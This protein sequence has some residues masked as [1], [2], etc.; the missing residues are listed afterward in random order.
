LQLEPKPIPDLPKL[1]HQRCH[2]TWNA[3]Q[4]I[5]RPSA[6]RVSGMLTSDAQG[7]PHVVWPGANPDSA[8]FLLARALFFVPLL[9]RGATARLVTKAHTWEQAASRAFA[10]ELLAP[11]DALRA[12]VG[13]GVSQEELKAVASHFQVSSMVIEHQLKNNRIGWIEEA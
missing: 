7:G 11:A 10:A 5:E 3:D 13:G 2:W 6:T 4:I 12:E 8:R 9:Q 1:L